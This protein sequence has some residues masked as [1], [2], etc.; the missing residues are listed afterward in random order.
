MTTI[1]VPIAIR[2]IDCLMSFLLCV[3]IPKA[4]LMIGSINGAII[5][6]PITTAA[7]LSIRPT[8]A[9]MVE[10]MSKTKNSRLGFAAS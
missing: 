2:V 10:M 4:R 3:D 8:V 7:L 5:I 9:M 1:N 6:A